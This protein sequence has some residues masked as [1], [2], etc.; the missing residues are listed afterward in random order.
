MYMIRCCC[1]L[2]AAVLLF[3]AC[4]ERPAREAALSQP[5]SAYQEQLSSQ[6]ESRPQS[7]TLTVTAGEE[8]FEIVNEETGQIIPVTSLDQLPSFLS[9]DEKITILD[10]ENTV[11]EGTQEQLKEFVPLHDG[12]YIY[13]VTIGQD[14]YQFIARC[15]FPAKITMESNTV[16][17]GEALV[18]YV[19]Y[20][21]EVSAYTDLDFQPAFFQTENRKMGILPVRYSTQPGIYQLTL[22]AGEESFPYQINVG[23]R[24]FEVQYLTVDPGTTA[25][26]IEN[27]AANLEWAEKIEPLKKICDPIKYW[28]GPFLQPVEGPITTEFGMIRYTNG[29]QVATRHSGIDIAAGAGTQ[30]SAAGA[31]RVL[32]ADFLQLTGNTVII[33]HGFGVKSWYYH[34]ESLDVKADDWVEQGNPVGKVGSTGFSTGP[35]LHF[36]MS[37]N[38]VF[39]NPWT[40]FER[41]IY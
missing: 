19:E 6:E 3:S 11:F 31:G 1:V 38:D 12:D 14:S 23:D 7:K 28:D 29:S 41:G 27:E 9:G 4:G 15:D 30:V 39:I 2:A 5:Q 32:F 34:M 13:R 40:A 24:E 20:A 17:L 21:E 26:T 10:G 36:C 33:E 18:I 37:V 35:H 8:S 22:T 25:N 16:I